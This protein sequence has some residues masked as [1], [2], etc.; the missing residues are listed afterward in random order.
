MT[1]PR[2][3]RKGTTS[4]VTRKCLFGMFLL[5]PGKLVNQIFGYLLA[6]A[7]SLTGIEVHAFCVMANHYHLVVTDPDARLPEFH[8]YLDGLLARAINALYGRWDTFWKAGSYNAVVIETPEDI[9]DKCAYV[10][11][12]PVAAGL[13]RR[14]RKWPGLWSDPVDIGRTLRFD[15][16]SHFFKDDGYMPKQ[17]E[18]E[19]TVPAGFASAEAFQAQ[20]ESELE[21]RE[22]KAASERTSVLG[23]ARILKQRVFDR[24]RTREPRRALRPRFAAK[25]PGRR[26]DLAH[27]LKEFLAGY[28]EALQ[29]WRDGKRDVVFPDGTYQMRVSHQAACAGAG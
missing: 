6:R 15:L 9:L 25:D 2:Q 10:L 29:A 17:V 24:P 21:A 7:A 22:A 12:N 16:P 23:V 1:A 28:R 5:R 27:R 18:L 11:A 8:Q 4:F 20:L 19:L 13:V 14:A 3:V 26:R